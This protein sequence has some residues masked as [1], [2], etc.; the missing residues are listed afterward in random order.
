MDVSKPDLIDEISR[1]RIAEMLESPKEDYWGP[2]KDVA[3]NVYQGWI[4]KNWI[5]IA[6]IFAILLFLAWR[7]RSA[8]RKKLNPIPKPNETDAF[9]KAYRQQ[10]EQLREPKI[11]VS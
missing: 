7:Y 3:T 2:A 4:T 10:Q 6:L 11:P 9:M 1:L 5:F 8:K